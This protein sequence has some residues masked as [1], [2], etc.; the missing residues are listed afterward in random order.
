[1]PTPLIRGLAAMVNVNVHKPPIFVRSSR[2][3]WTNYFDSPAS[4]C[5][6]LWPRICGTTKRLQDG[7]FHKAVAP[8]N[9][10]E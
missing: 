2:L 7:G 4:A 6:N 9:G 8:V 10:Y 5:T 3:T 1:M